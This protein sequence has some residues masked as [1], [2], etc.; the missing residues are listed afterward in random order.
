MPI[1]SSLRVDPAAQLGDHRHQRR[2]GDG[3]LALHE[4]HPPRGD[5]HRGR[6]VGEGPRA[7]RLAG[8]LVDPGLPGGP[9]GADLV[10]QSE[11]RRWPA[12]RRRPADASPTAVPG[13]R[14]PGC[15]AWSAPSRCAG[16]SAD[17]RGRSP[18]SSSAT[19]R[20]PRPGSP[21]PRRPGAGTWARTA[22][23]P[24]RRCRARPARPP[25]PASRAA[26]S[27]AEHRSTEPSPVT[28]VSARTWVASPPSRLPLPW[29]PVERA[30]AM[31]CRSMSPRLGRASPYAAR[32]RLRSASRVPPPTVTRPDSRSTERRPDRA[33]SRSW[34]PSVTAMGEKECPAPTALTVVPRSAASRTSRA[35]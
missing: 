12:A 28:R 20:A 5:Q 32:A 19:A 2:P 34:S 31:V 9:A 1:R 15:C 22:G 7:Q 11:Q 16:T 27:V 33:S 17:R 8:D 14:P 23:S 25:T 30:P 4:P 29:V 3:V 6:V 35:S 18:R 21:S 10:H 24:R 13:A 26:F